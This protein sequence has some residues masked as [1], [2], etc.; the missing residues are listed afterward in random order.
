MHPLISLA[1]GL[2]VAWALRRRNGENEDDLGW[3]RLG[4]GAVGAL[5]PYMEVF[6][7]LGGAGLY[8]QAEHGLMWSFLLLPL[9][10]FITA[11]VL[12]SVSKRGW[13]TFYWIVLG[14]MFATLFLGMLSNDGIHPLALLVNV[15]VG[16]GLVYDFD[17]VI[18]GLCLLTLGMGYAFKFW[19]RD[20]ARL[21]LGCLAIYFIAL[22]GLH[23]VAWRFGS[24]Y[25][26]AQGLKGDVNVDV[27]SQPLSPFNWRVIIT[28][29]APDGAA[30]LH[31]AFISLKGNQKTTP[32]RANA[33]RAQRVQAL[34]HS[35][36]EA[37][38]RVYPRFGGSDTN[39]QQQRRNKLAWYA[40][41]N[42]AFGW[43]ARYAIFDM[44]VKPP[45]SGIAAASCLQFV[46]LRLDGARD[47]A[48]GTYVLCPSATGGARVFVPYAIWPFAQGYHELVPIENVR[49]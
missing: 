19:Q 16:L 48:H 23:Y 33:L 8:Y 27:L 45:S 34:Y 4:A 12:G 15:R 6:F 7:W 11:G 17:G 37:E 25:A 13:G 20:I 9:M 26:D 28:E 14:S 39:A 3:W 31:D 47:S 2:V 32:L 43:Q 21:G 1:V 41:S 18:L 42:G 24:E 36:D 5:V 49:N 35:R 38:W 29:N 46:D 44:E 10:A 30:R 40:W 22:G